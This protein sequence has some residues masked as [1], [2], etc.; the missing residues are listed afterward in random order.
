MA[1]LLRRNKEKTKNEIIKIEAKIEKNDK[2]LEKIADDMNNIDVKIKAFY[3]GIFLRNKNLLLILTIMSYE[4]FLPQQSHIFILI[5]SLKTDK[6]KQ[7]Y[8]NS[9]DNDRNKLF[10]RKQLLN[11]DKLRL[12]CSLRKL[13]YERRQ[14]NTEK[15]KYFAEGKQISINIER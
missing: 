9:L 7:A 1:D 12:L 6:Q 15:C 3:N 4:M 10:I 11:S 8:L 13:L 5:A 14:L 2:K